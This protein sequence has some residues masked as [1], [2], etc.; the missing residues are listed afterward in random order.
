MQ[1]SHFKKNIQK[2]N[3]SISFTKIHFLSREK[4]PKTPFFNIKSPL[5]KLFSRKKPRN[6]R[7]SSPNTFSHRKH[8]AKTNISKQFKNGA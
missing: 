4:S 6:C 5:Q 2:I 3:F 8:S 7:K 1:L